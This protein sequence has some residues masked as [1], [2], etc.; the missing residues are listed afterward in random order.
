[1]IADVEQ[2][3]S[4][5]QTVL[6]VLVALAASRFRNTGTWSSPFFAVCERR[7]HQWGWALFAPLAPRGLKKVLV[8]F[9]SLVST[10]WIATGTGTLLFDRTTD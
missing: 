10:A 5:W 1:M 9:V 7:R 2:L 3:Q 4:L 8:P 6:V